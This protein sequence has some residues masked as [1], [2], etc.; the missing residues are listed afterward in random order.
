VNV[1]YRLN[2]AIRQTAARLK[3]DIL[4]PVLTST[5]AWCFAVIWTTGTVYL[6]AIGRTDTTIPSLCLLA[7]IMPLCAITVAITKKEH[8]PKVKL[9]RKR[10]S[11]LLLQIAV[12]AFFICMTLYTSLMFHSIVDQHP[13]PV[14]SAII[15]AFSRLGE[16]LFTNDIVANP[17]LS[18][19]NPAQ[20]FLIPLL[21]LLLL[22]AHVRELGLCRG[23]R[24]LSIVAL[25]CFVPVNVLVFLLAFGRLSYRALFR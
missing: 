9:S 12:I 16:Q 5:A 2:E 18:M 8:K 13:I 15:G 6:A 22:G 4:K 1:L 25:W 10:R 7:T 23:H 20:Y 14:W 3:R 21:I 19:A 11:L 24:T 17:A